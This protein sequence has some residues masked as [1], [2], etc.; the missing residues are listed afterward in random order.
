MVLDE[1]LDYIQLDVSY[2]LGANLKTNLETL[3]NDTASASRSYARSFLNFLLADTFSLDHPAMPPQE[4]KNPVS[5]ED[6]FEENNIIVSP[7]PSRDLFTFRVEGENMMAHITILDIQG[8]VLQNI[9]V[10]GDEWVID[11]NDWRPGTYLSNIRLSNGSLV[12][13][14]LIVQ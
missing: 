1:Y 11:S 5:I 4:L 14:I 9:E 8:R 2:Q 13:R 3:A 12:T 6:K 7:N 10:E